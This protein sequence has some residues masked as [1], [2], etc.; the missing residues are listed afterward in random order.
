MPSLNE[1]SAV[2]PL[3]WG[4]EIGHY[5]A[6]NP[7]PLV[8][9]CVV[10]TMPANFS[11]Y[12]FR[13][14]LK[15]GAIEEMEGYESEKDAFAACNYRYREIIATLQKALPE[16]TMTAE[17]DAEVGATVVAGISRNEQIIREAFAQLKNLTPKEKEL[18]WE[19]SV[20]N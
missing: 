11:K 14:F 7:H 8:R 18:I 6:E 2:P 17:F 16:P 15:S 19:L 5:V 4:I 1:I 20:K 10:D 3:V 12:R 9:K 13:I